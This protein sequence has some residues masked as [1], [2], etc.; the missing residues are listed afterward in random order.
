MIHPLI[1]QNGDFKKMSCI[2]VDIQAA[3][4][5]NYPD[6]LNY[7]FFDVTSEVYDKKENKVFRYSEILWL[8]KNDINKNNMKKY[9]VD[10][11]SIESDS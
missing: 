3:N 5:A 6:Y 4:N 1:K 9:Y 7:G 8:N 10:I 11:S 2:V